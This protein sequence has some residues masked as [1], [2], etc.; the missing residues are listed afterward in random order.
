[1]YPERKLQ[2]S[3]PSNPAR[4]EN[5][6]AFESKSVQHYTSM[7]SKEKE[8]SEYIDLAKANANRTNQKYADIIVVGGFE[9]GI[10]VAC[11][12]LK[13]DNS[14]RVT[15]V[16]SVDTQYG[17]GINPD[18]STSLT[19]FS[20]SR[21]EE[22]MDTDHLSLTTST[23]CIGASKTNNNLYEAQI[24]YLETIETKILKAVAPILLCIGFDSRKGVL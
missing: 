10:D 22:A 8:W 13:L 18:P 24:H 11:A 3:S 14:I 5:S 12:L 6:N 2:I 15:I 21:L 1:M 4:C 16:E 7:G 19:S 9:A 17:K 20:V 23:L